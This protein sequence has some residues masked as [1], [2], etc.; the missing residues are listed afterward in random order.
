MGEMK[1]VYQVK[2]WRDNDL[3]LARV[4][5]ASDGADKAPVNALTQAGTLA[6]V[7]PMARDL[8][9]TI[10][11]AARDT[12]DITIDYDLPD[13]GH[14]TRSDQPPVMSVFYQGFNF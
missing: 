13:V 1:P 11:D 5:G 4:V 6:K 7:D 10:L 12:F 3:W 8:I 14:A 2:A 9:A